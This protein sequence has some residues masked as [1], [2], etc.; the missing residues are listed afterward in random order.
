[1]IVSVSF[2][3]DVRSFPLSVCIVQAGADEGIISLM[4]PVCIVLDHGHLPSLFIWRNLT[5]AH[6]LAINTLGRN[7]HGS[8][9]VRKG[10][11]T[12]H[13]QLIVTI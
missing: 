11:F 12:L 13:K 8:S 5:A 3:A 2:I 1:M 9:D 4:V 7:Q 10:R 6:I